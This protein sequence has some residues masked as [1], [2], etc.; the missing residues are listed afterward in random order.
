MYEMRNAETILVWKYQ[1]KNH[2]GDL[3][4][5]ARLFLK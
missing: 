5:G 4:A 1:G 3:D 2:F